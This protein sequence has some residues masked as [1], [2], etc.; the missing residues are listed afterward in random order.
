MPDR[1]N[2]TK[3]G[4]LQDLNRAE[5]SSKEETTDPEHY[6]I[7]DTIK[8]SSPRQTAAYMAEMLQELQIMATRSGH[9]SLGELLEYAHREA[10]WRSR[11][12]NNVNGDGDNTA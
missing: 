6:K 4:D 10:V 9:I 2:K 1:D 12:G 11:L 3:P 7:A 5:L 8:S